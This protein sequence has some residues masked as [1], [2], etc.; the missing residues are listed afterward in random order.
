M[1]LHSFP[2]MWDKKSPRLVRV[3]L[4]V[5]FVA[6]ILGAI[7]VTLHRSF[8]TIERTH[9]GHAHPAS[10]HGLRSVPSPSRDR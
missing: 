9:P 3:V 8:T 6:F 1:S 4:R 2:V 10:T 5:C 7:I